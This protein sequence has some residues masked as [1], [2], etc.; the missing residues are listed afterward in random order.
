MERLAD[1][2]PA[3]SEFGNYGPLMKIWRK[4]ING[5]PIF[6]VWQFIPLG[7]SLNELQI[8]SLKVLALHFWSLLKQYYY[9]LDIYT[10]STPFS[11]KQTK[12]NTTTQPATNTQVNPPHTRSIPNFG[13]NY[14]LIYPPPKTPLY[15]EKLLYLE[16]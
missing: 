11:P 6:R 14:I 10:G 5:P 3:V 1:L 9:S 12:P 2:V 4:V 7:K 13:I 16:P 15:P 8:Q